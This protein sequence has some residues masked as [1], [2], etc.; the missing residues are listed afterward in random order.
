[1][2][3][4]LRLAVRTAI[5]GIASARTITGCALLTL[6]V[7]VGFNLALFGLIDRAIS[8]PP[9]HVVDPEQVFA[10]GFEP[11]GTADSA[12]GRPRMTTTSYVAYASIH[13][14]VSPA[15]T[16]AW[17]RVAT[18]AIVEGTQ[19]NVDATLVSD[20]YFALLRARPRLGRTINADDDLPPAGQPVAVLSHEFWR[21]VFGG[22]PDVLG[23]KIVLRGV[24]LTV[25]GVMPAGF[26]GHSAVHV[27]VWV[28]FHAVMRDPGWDRN[29]FVNLASVVIRVPPGQ[30][31]TAISSRASAAANRRVSL[32]PIRGA[33]VGSTE[34]RIAYWLAAVS[35][36]VFMIGLANTATLLLVRGA[37]RRRDLAI[38]IAL[39]ATRARLRSQVLVEAAFLA[40]TSTASALLLS[41]WL[42]E[43]LRRVL[44]P[45][46][47]ASSGLTFRVVAA[48]ALAGVL[49][50]IVAA[51]ADVAQ[52]PAQRLGGDL[53]S[54]T[55]ERPRRRLH[56]A[57][58]VFQTT[59][60]VILLAGAGLFARSLYNLAAQDFGM[61]MDD[62]LLVDFERGP[63]SRNQDDVLGPA[64]D[65]V[66]ALPGV[67]AVTP[68]K[69]IPFTGFNV[70]P[71]SVPGLADA[72]NIDG[73]LPFL[74]AAT[75]QFFDIL[76]VSIV[77]GR[78]F[79]DSDDR[80][81]P[82]V[83]VNQTMARTV[84]PG[85]SALG[86]CIRI[87]FEPSFDP[88]TASGPPPAPT[89]VPCREVVGV[90]RDVRQ[91]SVIPDGHESRLMQYFV[92]FSQVPP[93]PAGVNPGV[94]AEIYGLLLRASAAPEQLAPAIRR[95]VVGRRTDLPFLQ[96]RR[97]ADLLERQMRPWRL[98][99]LLLGIFGALALAVAAVGL[100][101]ASAH[102]VQERRREMAVRIAIGAAPRRVLT[103]VVR[104][105]ALVAVAGAL[106]GSTLIVIG[107]RWLQSLLFDIAP[108]DPIVLGAVG[109]LMVIVAA[110][111]TLLPAR[112]ASRSDPST[113][114]RA[115]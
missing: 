95:L 70:P 50:F 54:V 17:Q 25:V 78:R 83:V 49:A 18:A 63:G 59:I 48:A 24:D 61:R 69:T 114:L 26:S 42:D 12:P 90:A 43:A 29:P 40:V 36:L 23:R 52:L 20:A 8:S 88:F 109:G 113:L 65:R 92:P 91:R 106:C 87:G 103:M 73:Q 62:V 57:L 58:L 84:W 89:T 32:T 60:S 71:I 4:R 51:A 98:G 101:A 97:Y 82:V 10:A 75:P 22:D 96:V 112:S 2:S 31:A 79:V 108:S 76:G 68:I 55:R 47:S 115:E 66:R 30:N 72:P 3:D 14:Q 111:A 1:M 110:L 80:G 81:A 77:E 37:D 100:Y 33:D 13:D 35:I 27:D 9:P 99:T 85:Q 53:I 105:A 16:A 21:G 45:T 44:L 6:A 38:R 64:I 104:E 7:A 28:P 41:Y 19:L 86:K 74:T 11:P 15:E 107:G 94:R 39:G 93:P 102:S 56:V 34:R 67:Q 5:R 46:V